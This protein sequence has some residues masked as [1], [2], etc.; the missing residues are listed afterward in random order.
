MTISY[1]LSLPSR[2]PGLVTVRARSFVGVSDSPFTGEQQVFEH[3]GD[4]WI[5]EVEL[6][7]MER[8]DADD[9]EAF[10]LS[11]GGRAGTFLMGPIPYTGA[12][13]TWVGSSPVVAG[14]SQ[15]GRSLVVNGLAAGLTAQAG[16][17]FQLG[18]GSTASLHRVVQTAIVSGSPLDLRLD[19]WPR[20]RSSPAHGAAVTLASPKGRWRLAS[21]DVEWTR[22]VGALTDGIRFSC[23]EAIG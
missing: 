13:G 16:D 14:G 20:L 1:P 7:P 10:L 2:T 4:I 5:A 9:W 21:N 22:I 18:S 19:I 11:L 23:V 3:P 8:S 17:W 12:R 6:P 15:T